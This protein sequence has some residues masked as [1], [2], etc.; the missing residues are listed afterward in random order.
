MNNLIFYRPFLF[1]KSG[2]NAKGLMLTPDAIRI[3]SSTST[4]P[5]VCPAVRTIMWAISPSAAMPPSDTFPAL[6]DI[7][8]LRQSFVVAQAVKPSSDPKFN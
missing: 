3:W 2:T 6:T 5:S 4:T 1:V 8:R 7:C